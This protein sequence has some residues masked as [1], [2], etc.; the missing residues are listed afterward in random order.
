M[1][2][3]YMKILTLKGFL[4]ISLIYCNVIISS[5]AQQSIN[6]SKIEAIVQLAKFVDWSQNRTFSEQNRMLY[7][8]CN[9]YDKI[10][11]Q[12]LSNNNPGFKNW[13]IKYCKSLSEITNGSVIFITK[14]QK[15]N[16]KQVINL[17]K[18]KDIITISDNIEYFCKNGGMINLID[19]GNKVKFEINYRLVQNKSLE[20]SSKVLALAKIYD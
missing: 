9:A 10:S 16:Y 5:H 15:E 2:N 12:N 8:L 13:N 11:V 1:I 14:N 7:I 4:L 19:E 6:Q 18:T 20:I 17:S 3:C